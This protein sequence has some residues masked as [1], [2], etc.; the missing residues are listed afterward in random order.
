MTRIEFAERV[1]RILYER[2]PSASVRIDGP[3]VKTDATVL[4]GSVLAEI[5][6][7][8]CEAGIGWVITTGWNGKLQ[9]MY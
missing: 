6:K 3:F 9:I 1:V 2:Q 4:G 7:L 5:E 8:A